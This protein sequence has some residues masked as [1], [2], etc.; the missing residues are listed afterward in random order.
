MPLPTDVSIAPSRARADD[1]DPA[2]RR[3]GSPS[4]RQPAGPGAAAG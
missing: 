3:S 4:I 1:A 2:A